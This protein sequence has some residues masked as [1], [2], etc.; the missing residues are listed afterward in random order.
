MAIAIT[1]S[2]H[3]VWFYLIFLKKALEKPWLHIIITEAFSCCNFGSQKAHLLE[4]DEVR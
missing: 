4:R 2:A 3:H 1:A